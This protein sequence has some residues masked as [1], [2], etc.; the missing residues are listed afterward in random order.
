MFFDFSAADKVQVVQ[1]YLMSNPTDKTITSVEP[2]GSVITFTLPEGYE[3]LQ[4]QDGILGERY[5]EIPGGF[6]DTQSVQSGVT[7]YQVLV[8]FDLPYKNKL[9]MQQVINHTLSSAVVLLPQN[10]VKLKSDAMVDAGTR[11]V[12]G[13]PYQMFTGTSMAAGSEL[14]IELSGKPGGGLSFLSNPET[15]N[16]LLVGLGALGLVLILAGLWLFRRERLAKKEALELDEELEDDDLEDAD[17]LM[18]AIIALDDLYKNGELPE[19][20]YQQRRAEFK[21]RLEEIME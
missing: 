21:R 1:L 3:N 2:G 15:R 5:L 9:T 13:T 20:A 17:S 12:Q 19:D 18:D 8:A 4:F 16:S 6:A 14:K 11:D 7:D 10:G